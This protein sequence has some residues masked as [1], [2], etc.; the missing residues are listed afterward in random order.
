MSGWFL[1]IAVWGLI[2]ATITAFNPRGWGDA[3]YRFSKRT[4]KLG[5]VKFGIFAF[6][7]DPTI[8]RMS[9]FFVGLLMVVMG[10]AIF[11]STK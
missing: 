4:S 11:F 7:D 2:V 5:P 6:S 1:F 8:F 9:T 3:L 10:T